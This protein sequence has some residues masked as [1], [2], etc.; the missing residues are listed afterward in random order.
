MRICLFPKASLLFFGCKGLHT[1]VE[2][3]Y[4]AHELPI[5]HDV[6]HSVHTVQ[7]EVHIRLLQEIRR[8]REL[9]LKSPRV[10]AHPPVLHLIKPG[11]NEVPIRYCKASKS[12][13]RHPNA[14]H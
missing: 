1:P 5:N 4:S 12:M 2:V 9:L 11:Q 8:N 10:Q 14:V 13:A 7:K 6:R 3:L